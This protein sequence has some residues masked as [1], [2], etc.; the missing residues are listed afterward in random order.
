MPKKS[1]PWKFAYIRH[2]QRIGINASKSEKKTLIFLKRD[3]F[4]AVAVIDAKT[5]KTVLCG[6]ERERER[7]QRIVKIQEMPRIS[8]HV[9]ILLNQENS[10]EDKIKSNLDPLNETKTKLKE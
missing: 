4:A 9:K 5:L 8:R 6:G 7:V 2:F 1:T 3:V 10:H